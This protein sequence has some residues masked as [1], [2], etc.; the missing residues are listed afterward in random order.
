[1]LLIAVFLIVSF[2]M[3]TNLEKTVIFSPIFFTVLLKKNDTRNKI[4][5]FIFYINVVLAYLIVGRDASF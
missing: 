1:M 4:L 3:E 5:N 2:L